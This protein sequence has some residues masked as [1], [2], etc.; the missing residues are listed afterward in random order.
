M[1]YNEEEYGVW[2]EDELKWWNED[3][4]GTAHPGD[5]PVIQY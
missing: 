2:V 3:Y 5:I 4:A 1:I